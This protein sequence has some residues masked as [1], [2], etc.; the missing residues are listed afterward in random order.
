MEVPEHPRR[1]AGV[2][3]K[4]ETAFTQGVQQLSGLS[5][6]LEYRL[7]RYSRADGTALPRN[8]DYVAAGWQ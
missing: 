5:G 6:H 3:P 2:A 4:S 8:C 7:F 1:V